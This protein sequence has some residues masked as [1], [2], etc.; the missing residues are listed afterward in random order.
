MVSA[1]VGVVWVVVEMVVLCFVVC[2]LILVCSVL[3]WLESVVLVVELC[4]FLCVWVCC[5]TVVRV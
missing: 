4:C 3:C 2:E 1:S 5:Q